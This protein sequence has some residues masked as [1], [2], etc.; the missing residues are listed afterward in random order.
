MPLRPATSRP[1]CASG[2][3]KSLFASRGCKRSQGRAPE[4]VQAIAPDWQKWPPSRQAVGW[5]WGRPSFVVLVG[6]R[7]DWQEAAS[8]AMGNQAWPPGTRPATIPGRSQDAPCSISKWLSGVTTRLRLR[9]C[10]SGCE[11]SSPSHRAA[12]YPIWPTQLFLFGVASL[13]QQWPR[14]IDRLA[15][16]ARAGTTHTGAQLVSHRTE[17][18]MVSPLPTRHFRSLSCA[19]EASQMRPET[20]GRTRA[21]AGQRSSRT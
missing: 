13:F 8:T 12:S 21:F 9:Q 11:P 18:D 20:R 10:V 17:A 7:P 1:P 5:I 15:R 14:V 4:N 19:V 16:F 2:G 6:G 3:S